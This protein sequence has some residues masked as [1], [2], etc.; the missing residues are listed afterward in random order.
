MMLAVDD[1]RKR[2]RARR[3]RRFLPR[4]RPQ[5]RV[6]QQRQ[7]AFEFDKPRRL[8]EVT[9]SQRARVHGDDA[10][11]AG[12]VLQI[13]FAAAA[14]PRH[15]A[16][17]VHALL[18]A[19][20]PT[21][22]TDRVH[23]RD[24]VVERIYQLRF[25]DDEIFEAR[26]I[27]HS[28]RHVAQRADVVRGH[29]AAHGHARADERLRRHAHRH[30]GVHLQAVARDREVDQQ[31]RLRDARRPHH[32]GNL[33]AL[34]V[35]QTGGDV[36]D[37]HAFRR[38]QRRRP[39]PAPH[40]RADDRRKG[41]RVRHAL[42]RDPIARGRRRLV[43]IFHEHAGRVVLHEKLPFPIGLRGGDDARDRDLEPVTRL[44]AGERQHLGRIGQR[45][46][47]RIGP[48]LSAE[49]RP[50]AAAK[51]STQ[52]KFRGSRHDQRAAG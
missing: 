11:A 15:H 50:R 36:L 17:D 40:G 32:P 38:G 43:K 10:D 23:R 14:L 31:T 22:L 37:R 3:H 35:F 21:V 12:R 48:R 28:G 16:A 2:H 39:E 4:G 9:R 49:G 8:D 19:P 47:Q 27:H 6:A 20:P 44:L 26:H 25:D 34:A 30:A 45:L 29:G 24:R 41:S 13:N 18:R 33:D 51:Q 46:G 42:D 52:K 7:V 5:H 1:L